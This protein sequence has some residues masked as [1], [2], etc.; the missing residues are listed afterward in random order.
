MDGL[1]LIR[2]SHAEGLRLLDTALSRDEEGDSSSALTEY[3]QALAVMAMGLE[4]R[5]DLSHCDGAD[6]AKARK[7]QQEMRNRG[8]QARGRI[9]DLERLGKS[10]L[11]SPSSSSS[12]ASK[13]APGNDQGH[14]FPSGTRRSPPPPYSERDESHIPRGSSNS[15]IHDRT[16]SLQPPPYSEFPEPCT[17]SSSAAAATPAVA[18]GLPLPTPKTNEKVNIATEKAAKGQ[19]LASP[20]EGPHVNV[21]ECG[22]VEV[23]QELF[24]IPEGVRIFQV[25][26]ETQK[27]EARKPSTATSSSTATASSSTSAPSTSSLTIFKLPTPKNRQE[28]FDCLEYILQVGDWIFPL[29]QHLSPIL[30]TVDSI[31]MF[32]DLKEEASSVACL[33]TGTAIGLVLDPGVVTLDVRFVF[34]EKLRELALLLTVEEATSLGLVRSSSTTFSETDGSTTPMTNNGSGAVTHHRVQPRGALAADFVARGMLTGATALSQ[35]L[36]THSNRKGRDVWPMKIWFALRFINVFKLPTLC[37]DICS[38]LSVHA[39][40]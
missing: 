32:P 5:C 20:S 37:P 38:C 21:S 3:R 31:Y 35:G 23:T 25:D 39:Q 14:P 40:A 33:A 7:M 36:H 34:E 15:A 11:L 30:K 29:S 19:A 26:P 22:I 17:S 24:R 18:I 8:V 9:K 13:S 6:W 28:S 2:G 12:S 10:G 16:L 27:V 4:V 1:D